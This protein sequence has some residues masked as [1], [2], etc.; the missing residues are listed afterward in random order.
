MQANPV[1]VGPFYDEAQ[2]IV[3]KSDD[4]VRYITELKARCLST[5]QVILMNNRW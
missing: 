2:I 1:K 5:S 4:L 3:K